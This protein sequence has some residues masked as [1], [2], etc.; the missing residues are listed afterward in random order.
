MF[1]Y[2][3]LF[4]YLSFL[5]YKY[6][7]KRKKDV[8][9]RLH[10]MFSCFILILVAGFRYR[11]GYDT[12]NYMESFTKAPSLGELLSGAEYQGDFMWAYIYGFSKEIC[13]DFFIVQFIQAI[14]VNCFFFWFMKRHSPK[15]FVAVFLYFMLEWWNL[16]FEAMREAIAVSFFLYALD[17]ILSNKGLKVYYLRVWP[18]LLAHTFG[19]V[20][21]LFPLIKFLNIK[22]HALI[23]CSLVFFLIFLVKDS[24]NDLLLLMELTTDAGLET[25]DMALDKATKYVDS[26][27]YGESNMSIGGLLSLFVGNILPCIYIIMLLNRHSKVCNQTWVPFVFVYICICVLKTQVPIFYRFLNY[28]EI[29]VIVAYTNVLFYEK[30]KIKRQLASVFMFLMVLVRMYSLTS[31]DV[32]T[33]IPA[34]YRYVPYNSIFQKDYN[35]NSEIIFSN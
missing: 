2:I 21:L 26:D 20:T 1:I 32:D 30:L 25:S 11:I 10:Y 27:I 33:T 24:M 28:F 22:K 12:N 9:K 13:D 4:V 34:Y 15:P 35:K 5:V 16:C 6:D 19:F 8:N 14:I 18:A 31:N 23:I 7:V 29:L 3:V 17:A